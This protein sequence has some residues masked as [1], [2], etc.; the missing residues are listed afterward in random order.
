VA[1]TNQ[2]SFLAPCPVNI[3]LATDV[4]TPT[5][6]VAAIVSGLTNVRL[7]LLGIAD[8]PFVIPPPSAKSIAETLDQTPDPQLSAVLFARELGRRAGPCKPLATRLVLLNDMQSESRSAFLRKAVVEGLRECEC[9]WVDVDAFEYL[10]MRLLA[11]AYHF[12]TIPIQNDALD[13]PIVPAEP[14]LKVQQ[15]LQTL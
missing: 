3:Y 13:R 12:T 8:Q 15:W 4:S 6:K 10:V 1:P 11:P 7:L 9:S 5:G 2:L 14:E